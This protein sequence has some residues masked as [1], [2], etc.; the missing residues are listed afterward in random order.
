MKDASHIEKGRKSHTPYCCTLILRCQSAQDTFISVPVVLPISPISFA[1][2]C[3]CFRFHKKKTK[4]KKNKTTTK[5]ICVL[6]Q[7]V[8]KDLNNQVV[9]V[10]KIAYGTESVLSKVKA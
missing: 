10:T 2:L 8:A 4:N 5:I 9:N 6:Y 7:N 3:F 1:V